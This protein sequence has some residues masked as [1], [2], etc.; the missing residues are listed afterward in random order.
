MNLNCSHFLEIGGM[1]AG[2][3]NNSFFQKAKFDRISENFFKS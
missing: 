3:L 2:K 1:K